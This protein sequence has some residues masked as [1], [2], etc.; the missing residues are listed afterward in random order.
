MY[1]IAPVLPAVVQAVALKGK[2]P[3]DHSKFFGS[4]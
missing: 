3:K 2:I 1:V 4:W